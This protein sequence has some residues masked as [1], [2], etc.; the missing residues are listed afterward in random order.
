MNI[1]SFGDLSIETFLREYWQKKPLLI[2]N[3]LPGCQPLIGG[4]ELAGLAC[5]EGVESRLIIR[6]ASGERWELQHGPFS[7]ET[8]QALPETHWTLLVQ[9]VDHWIP[10][11]ATFL[12]QF[13]FIPSWRIDDLMISYASD[14]GGVGPHYDNYD[15]FLVQAGGRRQ[16][17]IGGLFDECSPHRADT[18]VT[19][20]SDWE[21][22]Q[23]WILDPGDMLYVPPR[24]GHSGMAVG[25]GCITYSVGF[26]A[27]SHREIL[28]EFS[29]YVGRQ[30]SEEVRFTDPDLVP[31]ANPGHMTA[32]VLHAVHQILRRYVDDLLHQLLRK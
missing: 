27:P 26:R 10:E 28:Q 8:F 24:V 15:V 29:G 12:Q 32:A 9:A 23:R 1:L 13:N 14:G 7:D 3:A 2:R 6:D 20:L 17:E 16:W 30:L 19:I 22:E 25:D 4:D 11:A 31:Q 21:P 5:E 18:P